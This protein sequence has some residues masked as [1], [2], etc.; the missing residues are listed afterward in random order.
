MLGL[1]A[2]LLQAADAGHGVHVGAGQTTARADR[3]YDFTAH[4]SATETA[5]F[6]YSVRHDSVMWSARTDCNITI[7]TS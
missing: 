5:H 3:E 1:R 7:L 4:V 6:R 2:L